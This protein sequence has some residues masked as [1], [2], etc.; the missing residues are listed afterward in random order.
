MR[1]KVTAQDIANCLH[2]SRITVSKALN[3][4][5][6]VSPDTRELVLKKAREMNYKN[7]NYNPVQEEDTAAPQSKSFAFVMQMN[8]DALH[9]G[10]GIMAQL[11]QEIRKKGY[12][13][14]LHTVTGQ[15]I[16]DLSL[17]A[18]LNSSQVEAAICLEMFHP[19]YSRLICSLDI[20]VLFID[21]CIHF[22]SLRPH[23]DLLLMKNRSSV[24]KM[25]TS[26][27]EKTP[28]AS[29]GFVG[30]INHCLSFHERYEGFLRAA[31]A[32]GA[33]IQPYNIIAPDRH[34]SQP[35][36]MMEQLRAMEKLPELFC[37]AND[38]LAQILIQNLKDFGRRVPEDVM[39]CGFDGIYYMNPTLNCLTTVRT[40][41][42]ELGSCAARLLFQRIEHPD[43][44]CTSTYVDT[45]IWFR[46][47]TR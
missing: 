46:D 21:A 39:V 33:A 26:V 38:A 27:C 37:C 9:I 47:T 2:L 11:E 29:M 3:N 8:P 36:W 6:N 5:P 35:G 28:F 15:D 25:L 44:I 32:C 12:S 24:Y 13:L 20:P 31:A 7:I 17:P 34:Y 19:E 16:S 18:N 41:C 10:S 1:T 43:Q 4:S 42:Q 23:G 45:E 22:Q 40:P 30:D 14:T